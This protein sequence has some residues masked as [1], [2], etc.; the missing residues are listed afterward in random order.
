ML[1]LVEGEVLGGA[2][3]EARR[4]QSLRAR[5][6]GEVEEQR[7]A[8]QRAALLEAAPEV[9]GAV[10]GH[11]DAGEDDDE[12]FAVSTAKARMA[13]DLDGQPVVWQAAAREQRQLLAAHQAV[14][15]V[16]RA[17]AGLD[18]VARQCARHRVQRQPFDCDL[19][20]H[21]DRRPA[22]DDL[23]H[24]VEDP[25]ENAWPV[26]RRRALRRESEPRCLRAT[27]R[28]S[29]RALRSS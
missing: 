14:H 15:Q 27:G 24:A 12:V 4:Q 21:R 5:V 19:A 18:E 20:M 17:D 1:A 16:Q 28:R 25:A 29:P 7:R 13:G 3:R 9:L 26:G 6:A 11:A 23:A 10:V 2:Q 8:L 22:V